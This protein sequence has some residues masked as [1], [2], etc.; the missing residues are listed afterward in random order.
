MRFIRLVILFLHLGI[1]SFATA[2]SGEKS[3]AGFDPRTDII[4]DNYEAGPYLI[5][6]CV[7]EHWTCVTEPYFRECEEKRKQDLEKN[8]PRARCSPLGAFPTKKSC[9]Q[10]ELFMTSNNHG[11]AFCS[12]GEWKSKEILFQ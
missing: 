10:R 2:D 5:Y 8:R 6:D 9:F 3:L 11:Q 4:A 7:E 12:I 1:L